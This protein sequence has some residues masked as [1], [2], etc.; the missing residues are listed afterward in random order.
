MN[1]LLQQVV[2]GIRDVTP[3]TLDIEDELRF[4]RLNS[5]THDYYLFVSRVGRRGVSRS[6]GGSFYHV[7]DI[8]GIS[9]GVRAF[10]AL[11]RIEMFDRQLDEV[12][13]SY[14]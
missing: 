9:V 12:Y 4:R 6:V 7:R 13:G 10:D 1:T 11:K 5:A 2:R 14:E 3:Q 8:I